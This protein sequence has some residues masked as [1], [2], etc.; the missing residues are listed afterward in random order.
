L[1]EENPKLTDLTPDQL[2]SY[3][4]QKALER[5]CELCGE[6]DWDIVTSSEKSAHL[7]MLTNASPQ[8]FFFLLCGNCGNSKM[9]FRPK[10]LAEFQSGNDQDG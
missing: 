1:P 4:S 9:L 8:S 3:I 6:I 2:Q 10:V 7:L 5:P